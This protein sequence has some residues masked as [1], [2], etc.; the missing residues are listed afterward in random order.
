MDAERW[1]REWETYE[2][3]PNESYASR[4]H[5]T[6]NSKSIM[7]LN[8]NVY[9]ELGEPEAVMLMYDKR[10]QT[11]GV[12]RAVEGDVRPFPVK[13]HPKGSHFLVHTANFCR[14]YKIVPT[15]NLRFYEARIDG[16]GVLVLRLQK[17]EPVIA[18]VRRATSG[19]QLRR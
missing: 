2:G 6:L 12:R 18:R 11:I 10:N 5:V 17:T 1:A 15:Y 9:R 16:N 14:F 19:H 13:M 4:L 8:Q 7:L 3:G